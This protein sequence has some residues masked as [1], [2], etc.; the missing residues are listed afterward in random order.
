M[1]PACGGVVRQ[2]LAAIEKGS[3]TAFPI[4]NRVPKS[5]AKNRASSLPF[6]KRHKT[7]GTGR[8]LSPLWK[9]AP[10]SDKQRHRAPRGMLRWFARPT[11]RTVLSESPPSSKVLVT[12]HAV[13]PKHAGKCFAKLPSSGLRGAL[14]T[15]GVRATNRRSKCAR[16]TFP[17]VVSGSCGRAQTPTG[18]CTLAA[19]L[20]KLARRLFHLAAFRA[21]AQHRPPSVCPRY[22]LSQ[23]HHTA[24][25][26]FLLRQDR[27]RSLPVR[28]DIRAA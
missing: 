10:P 7:R 9:A 18:S 28:S 5:Q 8:L 23:H 26:S 14:C 13:K 3:V 12:A 4:A 22:I 6:L 20:P 11:S 21:A 19:G 24:C 15:A 2:R 17:F 27:F 25:H 16:F 1:P